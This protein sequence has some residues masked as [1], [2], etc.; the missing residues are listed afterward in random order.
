M[1]QP[2]GLLESYISLLLLLPVTQEVGWQLPEGAEGEG[3]R[4]FVWES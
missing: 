4:V 2:D 3:C 1:L